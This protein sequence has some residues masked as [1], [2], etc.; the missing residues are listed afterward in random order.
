MFRSLRFRLAV[1]HALVLAVTLVLLG[2]VVQ[3][4]LARSVN[5]SATAELLASARAEVIRIQEGGLRPPPDSDVP[6]AADTQIAV[7]DAGGAPIFEPPQGPPTWLRRYPST[8]TDVEVQME[9]VR[10]VTLPVVAGG[11]TVGWVVVGRSTIAEARL[12]HRVRL[13]LITGGVLAV[14]ASLGA[15]WWLAGRA[16]RPVEQAYEAQAG[17][18]ADASHEFRT[19]L[20]FIRSGVEVLAEGNPALGTAVLSEIDYLTDI[21]RRLLSLARAEGSG[22]PKER[23]PVDVAAVSRSAVGRSEQ[24]SG[25]QITVPAGGCSATGDPKGFEAA[26]DAVL[27]NVAVH[28]GGRAELSWQRDGAQVVVSV[29]DHG[30]GIGAEHLGRAF[31]RFFRAD[32]SRT[33][34]TGGAG[35]G[36][37]LAR[38]MMTSQGGRVWI[39][40]TPGGGLTVHLALPAGN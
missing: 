40:P 37:A 33:R 4:L 27:E 19:P 38:T 22:D 23:V 25:T 24:A 8:V 11:R 1:S 20:T 28:G 13:L 5:E 18:A 39:T 29:T 12:L 9:P 10:V 32:P 15:G 26:L 21:T 14:V 17:F 30:P 35:L 31:D 16:V 34:D 6:S 2:V 3:V 36:L 7:F